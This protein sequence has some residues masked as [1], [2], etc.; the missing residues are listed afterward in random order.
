M[1]AKVAISLPDDTLD[2]LERV[3][4]RR[5]LSRS[6]AIAKAIV[7]WVRE[8][9]PSDD[10]RRYVEAYLRQPESTTERAAIATAVVSTWEKWK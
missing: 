3:R 10:D 9:E 6:A 8:A 7:A 5:G 4:K 1:T 2:A